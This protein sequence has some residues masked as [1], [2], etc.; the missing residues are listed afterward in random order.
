LAIKLTSPDWNSLSL[1]AVYLN[2]WRPCAAISISL[3]G[4]TLYHGH[5]HFCNG[6]H[7]HYV[8]DY[9]EERERVPKSQARLRARNLIQKILDDWQAAKIFVG[10]GRHNH[11][12]I[13]PK[14]NLPACWDRL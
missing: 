13:L 10:T 5:L 9:F 8:C 11:P 2:P 7:L 1:A 6:T 14:L 3:K 4:K 12:R